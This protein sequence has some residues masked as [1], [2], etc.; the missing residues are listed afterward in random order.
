[1]S[2][3]EQARCAR[4]RRRDDHR[5]PHPARRCTI[6]SELGTIGR[7]QRLRLPAPRRSAS[8]PRTPASA[9][10]FPGSSFTPWPDLRADRSVSRS[11]FCTAAALASLQPRQL[12]VVAVPDHLHH[13]VVMAALRSDQHVLCVKPLALKHCQAAEIAE[14]AGRPRPVCRRGVPQALR[15]ALPRGPGRATGRAGSGSSSWERHGSWSPTGTEAPTSSAGS[16]RRTL[17][18]SR[19]SGAT[20]WTSCRFITG[21]LPVEVSVVGVR[22]RFPERQRGIP[23]VACQG[24][25]GERRAPLRDERPGVPRPGRRQQRPGPLA[26]LRRAEGTGMIRHDDH[27]RGVSYAYLDSARVTALVLPVR[28]P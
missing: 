26:V 3:P 1:M 16:P 23:L 10:A 5:G 6:S 9:A 7:H 21:L 19:T 28:Q 4:H 27:D 15:Q 11:R 12:V 20:T 13:E 24:A 22:R 18:R 8:L 14:T 17:I 25:L 2:R